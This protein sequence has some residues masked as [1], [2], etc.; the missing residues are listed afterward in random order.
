MDWR[1]QFLWTKQ[2]DV[3]ARHS[4]QGTDDHR[5][6]SGWPCTESSPPTKHRRAMSS[7]VPLDA[8]GIC[9]ISRSPVLVKWFT[10]ALHLDRFKKTDDYQ[11]MIFA[12]WQNWN[13]K[14]S[15]I[16]MSFL[17]SKAWD[18]KLPV[19]TWGN[20][21]HQAWLS[22]A[23][24]SELKKHW[25]HVFRLLGPPC[26]W[27]KQRDHF[28]WS[29]L[30]QIV[31]QQIL[32]DPKLEY[33]LILEDAPRLSLFRMPSLNCW[34]LHLYCHCWSI[35][36]RMTDWHRMH[37]LCSLPRGLV[38]IFW[39]SLSFTEQPAA[40]DCIKGKDTEEIRRIFNENI[41]VL[42]EAAP[43]AFGESN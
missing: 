36:S 17:C 37:R 43:N 2:G 10:A 16:W 35:P 8:P 27:Q 40:K 26:L 42:T 25:N 12:S 22:P 39:I 9:W 20:I 24:L 34:T 19:C 33:A 29:N 6:W 3:T 7:G 30:M 31:L 28:V 1:S 38:G 4:H 32:D 23:F 14:T 15:S 18:F 13:V 21:S 41:R 11:V 5:N